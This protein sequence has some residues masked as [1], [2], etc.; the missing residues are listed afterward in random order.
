[1]P[2]IIHYNNN[3]SSTKKK[4]VL[5]FVKITNNNNIAQLYA[6]CELFNLLAKNNNKIIL[7]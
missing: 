4:S 7:L 5:R 6:Q 1:M 3:F 2:V